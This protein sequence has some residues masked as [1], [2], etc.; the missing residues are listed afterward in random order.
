MSKSTNSSYWL[1]SGFYALLDKLTQLVFNLGGIVL[2]FRLLPKE[3]ASVWAAYLLLSPFIEMARM[4]LLQNGMST[5]INA[6]D[7]SEHAKILT[8]SL[9]LNVCLSIL[10]AIFLLT[11]SGYI[12]VGW[13]KNA[14]V[15]SLL[16]IYGLTTLVYALLFQFNYVQQAFLD[17]RG[18]F[19]SSFVRNGGLF[20]YIAYLWWH[21]QPFELWQLA[22]CQLFV[23]FPA[24]AVAW[25]FARRY[26]RYTWQIDWAWV[27]KMFA[28][29][30]YTM[31]TNIATMVYKSVDQTLLFRYLASSLSTYNLAI[32]VNTLAEVPTMTLAAILFPQS[33]RRMASEG[34]SA[35]RYLY[36]K[37]VGVLLALI[38]P[39]V[40]GIM[41]FAPLIVLIL[42][43]S[44]YA[45]AVPLLRWTILYG[46]FTVYAVQFGT[47]LDSI[48]MPRANFYITSFGAMVN[49]LCNLFFVQRFGLYGA[50]YGSLLA[51]SIMFCIMQWYLH[52]R[53][54]SL[55]WRAFA[56]I[57]PFYRQ[58]W[59]KG[60]S[61][62]GK[63]SPIIAE[64]NTIKETAITTP[65]I[66]QDMAITPQTR[67]INPLEY[68]IGNAS[69]LLSDAPALR[70]FLTDK[71][72]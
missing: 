32:R 72:F 10:C 26:Q 65:E 35:A 51:M 17:F 48:G 6:S 9:F 58:M 38:L 60:L 29:G 49:L 25:S 66:H 11:C 69:S 28:Y 59:A 2:L 5:F 46:I 47:M 8:A 71:D 57:F 18:L 23:A 3:T 54:G 43:G 44:K 36:E 27:H 30:R 16:R 12:G 39:F 14:Q 24:A 37:S 40:L 53:I 62:L 70:G 64:E 34:V 63:K 55:P 52:R 1:A 7:R 45:D 13:F 67:L 41:L 20:A 4:G 22:V 50:I 68:R 33:A 19:W 42:G 56:H 15:G 61:I 21:G 31:G